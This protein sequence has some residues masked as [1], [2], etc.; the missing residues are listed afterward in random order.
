MFSIMIYTKLEIHILIKFT[1][2]PNAFFSNVQFSIQGVDKCQPD[3]SFSQ[4]IVNLRFK[5]QKMTC[6]LTFIFHLMLLSLHWL[7]T[8]IYWSVKPWKQFT[9][10][11]QSAMSLLIFAYFYKIKGSCSNIYADI[12]CD[13]IKSKL[14]PAIVDNHL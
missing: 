12:F 5:I 3:N 1:Y 10:V 14:M 7:T 11:T 2:F 9:S 13:R 4:T 8:Q 6:Q